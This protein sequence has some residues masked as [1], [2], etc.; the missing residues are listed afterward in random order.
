VD[1]FDY[2]M[3]D[4]DGDSSTATLTINID[5]ELAPIDI[6]GSGETDDTNL[7]SGSNNVENGVINVNYQGETAGST[8]GTSGFTSRGSKMDG[9]LSSN[10]VDVTVKFDSTTNTY[11]GTAGSVTV[12]TMVINED[13]TY[14]FTQIEPLD[15]S[16]TEH[17]NE[18]IFL[19]FGVNA[20][21]GDGDTG[22]AGVVTITVRD[23]AP[24]AVDDVASACD[25]NTAI[26]GNVLDNDN[27]GADDGTVRPPP[28]SIGIDGR[29]CQI[30][31]ST[32][33]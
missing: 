23:D 25:N 10:G 5:A 33:C 8:F 14:T 26:I 4:A 32:P 15:H 7:V 24:E 28:G 3:R 29:S 1:E 20:V 6:S 11:T 30:G 9:T 21:D 22:T 27:T 13:A 19:Y 2:T 18:A 31:G 16:S 17:G 12:F